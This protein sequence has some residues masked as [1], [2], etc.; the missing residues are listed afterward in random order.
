MTNYPVGDFVTRVKN[1]AMSDAKEVRL[2]KTKLIKAVAEA[3]KREGFLDEVSEK[4]DELILR[5][6]FKEKEPLIIDLELV[7]RPGLRIYETVEELESKKGPEVYILSTSK[8]VLSSN[9]AVKKNIGGEV[10][11][12]AL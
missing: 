12:K 7:S 1:A 6:A 8:G 10:I 3:L 9:E 2:G 5:L 11:L 4:D